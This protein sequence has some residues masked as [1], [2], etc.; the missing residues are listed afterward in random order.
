M[1]V[2]SHWLWGGGVEG[3]RIWAVREEQEGRILVMG[4]ENHGLISHVK[5]LIERAGVQ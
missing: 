5:R 2:N 1:V 4:A 3:R